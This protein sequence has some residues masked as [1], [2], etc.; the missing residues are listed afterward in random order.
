MSDRALHHAIETIRATARAIEGDERFRAVFEEYPILAGDE[1]DF[2]EEEIRS[3]LGKDT[4]EIPATLRRIYGVTGGFRFQWQYLVDQSGL[5]NGSA[6][7][8]TL[9]EIYQRDDEAD[10]P[11]S[12]LMME[13][14]PFDMIGEG[15]YVGID[16]GNGSHGDLALTHVDEEE[17]KS[18]PLGLDPIEYL[19]MLA[20][21]RAI[22]R[23]QSLFEQSRP[24][25]AAA[26]A[27]IKMHVGRIFGLEEG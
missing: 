20:E 21:Y 27:K 5:T 11:M 1:L 13:R 4:Y 16:F 15:E 8:M 9:I 7:V 14:R 2:W 10:T 25:N 19:V 3:G 6:Q 23:W 17:R 24:A 12:K 26:A 22:Y 18:A